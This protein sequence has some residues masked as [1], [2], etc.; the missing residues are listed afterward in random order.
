MYVQHKYTN[1]STLDVEMDP[2]ID[3]KTIKHLLKKL[4]WT[5][6]RNHNA[7]IIEIW[8]PRPWKIKQN[9]CTVL[10]FCGPHACT[11]DS[12]IEAKIAP[13]SKPEPF[14]TH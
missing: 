14:Q 8:R 5:F 11:Q 7:M 10:I 3:K 4:M 1:A 9:H 2:Q 6:I 12:K 13:K